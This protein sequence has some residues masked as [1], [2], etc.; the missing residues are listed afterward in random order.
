MA[1]ST[2]S[3]LQVII[4]EVRQ[5][6]ITGG[7]S[8]GERLPTRMEFE[9]RFAASSVTIQRALDRLGEDGF[10][11]ARGRHGTFVASR[12]PHL[13]RYG[14][15]I[16]G[17]VPSP[18][19]HF[20]SALSRTARDLFSDGERTMSVYAGTGDPSSGDYQRLLGD[21][22]ARR[23]A[24]L[25]FVTNPYLLH[26]SPVV[27]QPGI[28]RVVIGNGGSSVVP[29]TVELLGERWFARAL[30][31]LAALDRRR[32]ALLAV[33]GR[34]ARHLDWFI[35][36]VASRGMTTDPCW[37]QA[38]VI[39]SPEWA[40]NLSQ[41][42]MRR[43][44]TGPVPDALV[45]ADDNLV[46]SAVLGLQAAGVRVPEDVAVVA[47]ANF[48]W[49]TRSPLPVKRLG[50]DARAILARCVEDLDRQR[51][52]RVVTMSTI[53]PVFDHELP[54]DPPPDTGVRRA[55]PT[56]GVRSA[57]VPAPCEGETT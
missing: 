4:D 51:R 53:D 22:Q 7:F 43:P 24:G 23:L 50:Y 1:S 46:E 56:T 16:P 11:E 21:V 5:S 25:I 34:G 32:V 13:V 30:D 12:P 10:I 48:P 15:V 33:P 26:Q 52:E 31:H 57:L 55:V 42:M 49:P 45:I 29:S 6:I 9:R 19:P 44:A 38:M 8:P 2:L 36:A 41:L 37:Q 54:P 20:W 3:R 14:L 40:A 18:G 17:E 35:R 28:P 27:D 47:H 39:S